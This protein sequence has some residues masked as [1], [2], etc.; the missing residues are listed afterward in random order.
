MKILKISYPLSNMRSN[1]LRENLVSCNWGLI[2][3]FLLYT[4][5]GFAVAASSNT[6]HFCLGKRLKIELHTDV[7]ITTG[8][9]KNHKNQSL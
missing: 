5:V 7:I 1:P 9:K 2:V 4:V 8:A 6:Y 3:L